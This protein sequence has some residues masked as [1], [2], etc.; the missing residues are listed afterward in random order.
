MYTC[1]GDI[2]VGEIY[3]PTRVKRGLCAYVGHVYVRRNKYRGVAQRGCY[4]MRNIVSPLVS[5][6]RAVCVVFALYDFLWNKKDTKALLQA[7]RAF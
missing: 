2:F 5:R 4:R 3:A 1:T 7:L 6:T